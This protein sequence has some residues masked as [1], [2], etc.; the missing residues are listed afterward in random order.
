MA[1]QNKPFLFVVDELMYLL[2]W[3]KTNIRCDMTGDKVHIRQ[4]FLTKVFSF[5]LRTSSGNALK[6]CKQFSYSMIVMLSPDHSLAL[7]S[8][9][10]AS[11]TN[12]PSHIL[13]FICSIP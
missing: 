5:I 12:P 9:F 6:R 8:P 4:G 7:K 10:S 1:R 2:Q 3:Q 13:T 11:T